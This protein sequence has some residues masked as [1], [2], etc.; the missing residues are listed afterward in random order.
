M[1]NIINYISLFVLSLGILHSHSIDAQ[2]LNQT[3]RGN[4]IDTDANSPII[5]A[6]VIIIDSDPLLGSSTG[7][8]GKFYIENVPVGRVS[9]KISCM[10][11]EEKIITNFLLT[12]TKELILNISLTESI[13]KMEEIV[14]RAKTTNGDVLNEMA[15]VSARAFS[16]EETKR[17]AGSFNDPSRMVSSFAGVMIAPEGDNYISVRGNSPKGMQWRLE[18]VE[19]PSPNHFS[20][21]G[22]TGGAINALNSA[23]LANSDFF[24]QRLSC[25][26]WQCFLRY[27]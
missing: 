25:R 11:Y 14:I 8:D 22:S 23:M 21:E 26:I 20:T 3:I 19:I 24:N 16:V 15:T 2:D 4:I 9:L 12:S 7:I 27:L 5:G 1:K 10:G 6:N 13:L 17:Y 18:G